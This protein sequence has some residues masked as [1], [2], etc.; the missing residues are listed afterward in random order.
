MALERKQADVAALLKKAGA[1]DPAPPVSVDAAVLESYAGAYRSEQVPL[2]IKVFVKEGK[3]YI[4]AAG[5]PEFAPK[6]ESATRFGF[7]PAQLEVEFDSAASFT[8]K[9]G[10]AAMKFKKAVTQ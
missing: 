4:Q 6:P 5:Q 3:L 10:G 7:A 9:Q 1:R 2:E 8:L